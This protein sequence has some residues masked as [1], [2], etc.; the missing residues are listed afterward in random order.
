MPFLSRSLL[1]FLFPSLI[2][3]LTGCK[4]GIHG[5]FGWASLDNRGIQKPE[6]KL[7]LARKFHLKRKYLHFYDYETIWW[8]YRITGGFYWDHEFLA[9]LYEDNYTPQPILVDLREAR[10][11]EEGCCDYIRY[12]YDGLKVGAYLLR[13]VYDSKVI[14]EV[15]FSVYP[16]EEELEI[17]PERTAERESRLYLREGAEGRGEESPPKEQMDEIQRYSRSFFSR[18]RKG[19]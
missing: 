17:N 7:R 18:T 11:L 19:I 9:A 1:F 16:T 3:G 12:Y 15:K 6:R 14:D 4:L 10:L 2:W 8:I 13:I 5:E